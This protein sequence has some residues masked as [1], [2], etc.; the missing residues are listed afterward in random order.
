MWMPRGTVSTGMQKWSDSRVLDSSC[1]LSTKESRSAQIVT[2]WTRTTGLSSPWIQRSLWQ[3]ETSVCLINVEHYNI[4]V[5]MWSRLCFPTFLPHRCL[6]YSICFKI[7]EW[8]QFFHRIQEW[9][10]LKEISEGS[11][12]QLLAQAQLSRAGCPQPC[13]ESFW[14]SPR[15]VTPHLWATCPRGQSLSQ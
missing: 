14:I 3:S 5:S 4:P 10:R 13:P 12:V 9:L 11:L 2:F 1:A 15:S 6:R 7:K 8:L